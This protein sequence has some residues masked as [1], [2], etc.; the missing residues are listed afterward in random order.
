[1]SFQDSFISAISRKVS[2]Q[3]CLITPLPSL[4]PPENGT[5]F[6]VSGTGKPLRQFIYSFDLAKLFIWVMREYDDVEPVILSGWCLLRIPHILTINQTILVSEDEEVSIK[7][8]AD[9]IV[10]SVGFKGEYTVRLF[11]LLY[12]LYPPTRHSSIPAVRMANSASLHQTKSCFLYYL[13]KKAEKKPLNSPLSMKPSNTLLV[14][15]CRTMTILGPAT[16]GLRND[17]GFLRRKFDP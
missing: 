6:V 14:G 7:D 8:L 9:T 12:A 10:K 3:M 2:F 5:P 15:S 16:S 13:V 1:M 4:F 17:R 11:I